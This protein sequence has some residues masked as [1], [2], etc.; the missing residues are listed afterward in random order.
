MAKNTV[1]QQFHDQKITTS[2]S[3]IQYD[4]GMT[5]KWSYNVTT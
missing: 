2:T 1:L 5:Q 4:Y 3:Q